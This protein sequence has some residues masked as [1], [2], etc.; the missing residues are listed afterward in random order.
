[1]FIFPSGPTY[2]EPMEC[3]PDTEVPD[4]PME[5]T[6]NPPT[7]MNVQQVCFCLHFISCLLVT[8]CL[9]VVVCDY[10]PLFFPS[11]DDG[12]TPGLSKAESTTMLCDSTEAQ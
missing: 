1:M 11:Q 4:S 5:S 10:Y 3:V 2:T 6:T 9:F 12:E 7:P 8:F